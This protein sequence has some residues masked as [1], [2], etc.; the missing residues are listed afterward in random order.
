MVN[1]VGFEIETVSEQTRLTFL[2]T[3]AAG[4]GWTFFPAQG[5]ATSF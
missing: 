3:L 5:G 1:A 2:D 4:G